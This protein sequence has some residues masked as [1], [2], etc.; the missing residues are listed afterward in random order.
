V[1]AESPPEPSRDN[2]RVAGAIFAA[3]VAAA[4]PLYLI[5]GHEQGFF[6]DEWDFLAGRRATSLHDLFAPHN[7]H[8]STLPILLYRGLWEVVG[9]RTYVPYQA[10]IIVLHLTAATLLWIVMRRA[11][12]RPFVAAAAGALFVLLGSGRQDIVWAF[13]V[14]FV[15]SLVCGLAHVLLADHDGPRTRNDTIGLAFGFAGL[16]CSGVAVTMTIVVGLA[17]L[18]RRGWRAASFHV[19]PLAGVYLIWWLALGRDASSTTSFSPSLIARFVVVG[20]GH[21]FGEIGQVPGVGAALALLLVVG[22]ALTFHQASPGELRRRMAAPGALLVGGIAFLAISAVGRVAV[23]GPDVARASR[24]VHIF[25]A[26]SLPALAVAIDAVTRRWRAFTPVAIIILLVGVPGNIVA[27]RAHGSDRFTLGDLQRVEALA[28]SPYAQRVPRTAR[29]MG[30]AGE[31]VTV[32]WLL[33]GAASGRIPSP[34]PMTLVQQAT[35]SLELAL[36]QSRVTLAGKACPPLAAPEERVLATGAALIFTSG[37]IDVQ[38]I[39]ADG[40]VSR[41]VPFAPGFGGRLEA[42]TGPLRVRLSPPTN[43]RGGVALCG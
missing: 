4:V 28:Y 15:G 2:S 40:T 20:I 43:R 26:M 13:Q 22:L 32:G 12:V 23:L 17:V 34:R 3:V 9:L 6:L 16:L 37:P 39:T 19:V 36:G 31:E 7:E 41:R 21:A 10:F 35:I 25:A 30:A 18:I 24:Y 14:G 11:G 8:W 29:P 5:R 27:I 42:L 38:L 1:A 33:D